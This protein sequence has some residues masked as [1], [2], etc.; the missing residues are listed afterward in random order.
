MEKGKGGVAVDG[1]RGSVAERWRLKLEAL[2]STP[3]STTF[4]LSFRHY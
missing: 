1:S 4:D 2:G 3:G